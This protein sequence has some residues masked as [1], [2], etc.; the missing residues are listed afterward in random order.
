ML[1]AQNVKGKTFSK[2]LRIAYAMDLGKVG[3]RSE[4]RHFWP[5]GVVDYQG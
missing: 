5:D 4:T 2:V 3:I 1:Y